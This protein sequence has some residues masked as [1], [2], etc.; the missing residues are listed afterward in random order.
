MRK[1]LVHKIRAIQVFAVLHLSNWW[2]PKSISKFVVK[3]LVGTYDNGATVFLDDDAQDLFEK[4]SFCSKERKKK[5]ASCFIHNAK[6]ASSVRCVPCGRHITQCYVVISI[7][8]VPMKIYT[9]SNSL[10]KLFGW[11]SK[12]TTKIARKQN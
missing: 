2:V 7:C 6:T 3:Y 9:S 8:L 12:S 11:I 10:R 1:I 5:T 4:S